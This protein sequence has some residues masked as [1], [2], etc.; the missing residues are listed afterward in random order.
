MHSLLR[1]FV[2]LLAGLPVLAQ[3]GII[4]TAIGG[5]PSAMP[6][7][8]ADL[9]GPVAVAVD[10]AGNYYIASYYQNRVFKVDTGGTLTVLAGNGV[11]GYS[12]DGVAGGAASAELNGPNGIAVDGAGNVYVS[13]YSSC[14]IR[15]VDATK[16]ITT[17][18]GTAGLC[19]FNADGAPA[20]SSHVS[21]PYGL[22]TDTLGNLYIADYSNCRV[23]KLALASNSIS[24][25]AGTGTCSST[26]DL[27]PATIATVHN[28][29]G[30]ATDAA[31]NIYIADTLGYRIRQVTVATGIINTIAGTG[32][33]GF[34]GDNGPATGANITEVYQG[35]NANSAGTTVTFMD[36]G[37]NRVRQFTV[38]GNINT[39]AGK[40]TGGFCGDNGAAL[41]ACFSQAQGLAM[42]SS[43]TI[44]VADTT[45]DR[46]RQF[47]AGGNI[48]TVAGNGDPTLPTA[49]DGIP[50]QGVVFNY[51]WGV[52]VDSLNNVVVSD[53]NS[54]RVRELVEPANV[55]N[56]LAGTG[57]PG[58]SGDNGQAT[59][60]LLNKTYGVSRDSL[61]NI[62]ISDA[63]NQ[64]IRKVDSGGIIATFAGT[65]GAFGYTGDGGL[66]TSAK[67]GNPY[68]VYV[69]GKNNVF[70]A[71]ASNHVIRKVT[72]GVISTFAGNHTAGYLGDGDP[73]TAAELN[74]PEGVAG[75]AAGNIYIAD[76]N[77]CVIRKVDAVTGKI[78]TVAG[79]NVCTFTGDGIATVEALNHPDGLTADANGNL[80]IADTNN[81]R[82][83]WVDTAGVL[84]TIGGTGSA[85]YD[86]D[87]ARAF[88]AKLDFPSGVTEDTAGNLLVADQYNLRVR[89]ISAFAALNASA[90]SLAFG[91][92]SMGGASSTPQVVTLSSVGPLTI[93]SIQTSGDF[94]E[95]DNCGS[96]LPNTKTCKVFVVFKPKAAGLRTGTLTIQDNGLFRPSTTISLSGTGSAILITGNPVA[97]D[98]QLSKTTSTPKNVTVTNKGT[99]S[100][101]MGSIALTQTTD[102]AISSNTCPA[103]GQVLAATASCTIGVVFKPQ[104][105]GLKKGAVVINDSDPSTPQV[106]GLSG[107]GIS[108]VSF[109]PSTVAFAT[110]PVGTTSTSRKIVLTNN[111]GAT[112]TLGN[113]AIAITGPFS[114]IGATSC[115]NGLAILAGG[116]CNIFVVFSPTAVGFPTGTLTVTDTDATSPQSVALSGTASGVLFTPSSVNFGTSA[117]GHQVSST[118]TITNVGPTYI[119]FTAGA[120][121]GANSRDFLTGATNPPCAGSLA[122]GAVC[123]FSMYFTPSLIG[124]ESAN[125]LVYDS[126]TGSPQ[127]LPLAGTGQ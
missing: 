104:S 52:S 107:T 22:A 57:S 102:F 83:R 41:Q 97:F 85:G 121:T 21:H 111:T 43:G 29:A 105:T 94:S 86:G 42:T 58:D 44:Y 120:I 100:I 18:A 2:A 12:G 109:T 73:A 99:T 6:A 14:V 98:N 28:P 45:N 110:Q 54:Y 3:Q 103:P 79:N 63:V 74:S 113:P 91:L 46:V 15:K 88:T 115:T 84:T 1:V 39:I 31:G 5:G 34:T 80:F 89:G 61:G 20:T 123:T 16:T 87:G 77:N 117:V 116:T 67:L 90:S 23:R 13:E 4:S 11:P 62:Y 92:V 7:V 27:G 75:D 19:G 17:I 118:V 119:S 51:P 69:D 65:P 56:L 10:S 127:T 71:D 32:T 125:Y 26:G 93:S 112:L 50:P 55:V 76:T 108:N 95:F 30:V 48:S 37:N 81:H 72:G 101:T 25:A 78:S 106:V 47:T 9:N 33:R 64:I 66:A 59:L 114:K 8:D 35:I 122:P 124:T 38:G 70:I 24:T 53:Q 40:G 49:I 36:Y 60:A 96:S 126:S 68:G 82:V